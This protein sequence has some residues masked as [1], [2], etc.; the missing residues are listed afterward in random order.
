MLDKKRK[1]CYIVNMNDEAENRK[2]K[3]VAAT[4]SLCRKH[5]RVRESEHAAVGRQNLFVL[6]VRTV[7]PQKK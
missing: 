3:E 4:C 2:Q 6:A 5:T 1:M 7:S